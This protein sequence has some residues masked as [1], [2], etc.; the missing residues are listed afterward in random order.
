[1]I[2]KI[3]GLIRFSMGLLVALALVT[4]CGSDQGHDAEVGELTMT[5][6]ATSPLAG[7]DYRLR[8]AVFEIR[9]PEDQDVSSEDYPVD[10]PTI[11]VQL[12]SGDYQ[13]TLRDGWT[14]EY[15]A[16]GQPYAQSRQRSSRRTRW[17]SLSWRTT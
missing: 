13:V 15:S 16:N 10:N 2:S 12:A 4:S 8:N 7:V 17:E 5:L 1:M 11:S 3:T 9:G 14:M 6:A